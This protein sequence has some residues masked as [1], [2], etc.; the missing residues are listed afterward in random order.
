MKATTLHPPSFT[1]PPSGGVLNIDKPAAL[2][3]H[4][5]VNQIRRIAGIRR[6]GH[7]GTLDPLATGVL[8]ICLGRA[9]RL[10]EYLTGQPKTYLATIRLGQTTNT[11]DAEGEITAERPV[12]ATPQEIEAALAAFRGPISQLP[13]M[14]SAV[15]QGG[16]PLYKLARQ[17]EEVERAPRHVTIYELDL[18]PVGFRKPTG[19]LLDIQLRVVCSA[20]T[21]IRS[22]AHDLGQALSC[23]GHI[24]QLR[25]TA[26]GSFTVETA[27]PLDHLTPDNLPTH[28]LPPDAAVQHLPRLDVTAEEALAL[29]QGK[30]IGSQPTPSNTPLARAYDE[31][32][33]FLGIL[34][35]GENGWQPHKILA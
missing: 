3:S 34:T 30:Q 8:L 13:P 17:G 25:R 26:V 11:Y 29:Q 33:R 7:A 16:R 6:V 22:L 28:L 2:T 21:Y 20:G 19:S 23:G 27:V 10:V 12:T 24:T 14:F 9:T 31:N 18:D 5:V 35:A 15:K 4:D 32:G 1:L